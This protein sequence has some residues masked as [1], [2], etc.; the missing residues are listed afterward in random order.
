VHPALVKPQPASNTRPTATAARLQ[1]AGTQFA[2]RVTRTGWHLAMAGSTH[3]H[4][5]MCE[6]G[7][8]QMREGRNVEE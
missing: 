2:N 8:R 4:I 7:Q 3:P 5:K 1:A 6:H